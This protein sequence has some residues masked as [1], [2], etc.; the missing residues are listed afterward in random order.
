MMRKS[1]KIIIMVMI[2]LFVWACEKTD[3]GQGPDDKALNFAVDVEALDVGA[4]YTNESLGFC[5]ELTEYWYK[6]TEISEHDDYIVFSFNGE[7]DFGNGES[8][9]YIG[10]QKALEG[11]TIDADYKFYY[12]LYASR[13]IADFILIF[14]E[15]RKRVSFHGSFVFDF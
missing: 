8:I 4:V 3:E 10:E 7:T 2:S 13:F 9:L 14:M 6:Y 15:D 5:L 11:V 1:L 12:L